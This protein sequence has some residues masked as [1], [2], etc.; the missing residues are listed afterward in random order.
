MNTGSIS[1]T[2]VETLVFDRAIVTEEVRNTDAFSHTGV[3]DSELRA[4]VG[5]LVLEAVVAKKPLATAAHTRGN[6]AVASVVV[7]V[8]VISAVLVLACLTKASGLAHANA[9]EANSGVRAVV[10]TSVDGTLLA[11][12]ALVTHA[13]A[14]VTG[15]VSRTFVRLAWAHANLAPETFPAAVADTGSTS[16]T[17]PLSVAVEQTGL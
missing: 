1:R 14:V 12:V 2:I 9:I 7:E 8:T 16:E 17:A 10:L 5:T 3:T 13:L 6:V 4:V 15:S 11:H